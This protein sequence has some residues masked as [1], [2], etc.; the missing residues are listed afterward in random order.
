MRKVMDRVQASYV[1]PVDTSQLVKDSLKGMLTGLDPHSDYMDENEYR[2]ILSDAHG[3]FSGIGA[4]L[5]RDDN[6]PKILSPIDD[7]PAALAGLKPGDVILRIDGQ[8]TDSLSLKDAV[9]KLR[10]ETGTKV[11]M[12]I[13]RSGQKP[14]EVTLTRALIRV[15]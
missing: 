1:E 8:P 13:S 7:T 14:F 5:T 4:E 3:E 15:A 6:H 12:T 2:E 10:G 11:R 9:D